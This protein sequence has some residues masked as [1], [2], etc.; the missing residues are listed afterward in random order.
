MTTSTGS[1]LPARLGQRAQGELTVT[2]ES[3][4][5]FASPRT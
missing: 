3:H 4:A 2:P 5:R 1:V